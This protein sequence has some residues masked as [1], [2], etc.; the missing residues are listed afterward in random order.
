MQGKAIILPEGTIKK[1]ILSGDDLEVKL[2]S[3]SVQDSWNANVQYPDG[4]VRQHQVFT[5]TGLLDKIA[6]QLK[7]RYNIV[8]FEFRS[9]PQDLT[10]STITIGG[11]KY[12]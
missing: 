1:I 4:Y 10:P 11:I 5:L 9:V 7:T 3:Y 8:S 12:A 2:L 6:G